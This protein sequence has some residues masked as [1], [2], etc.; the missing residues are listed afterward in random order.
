LCGTVINQHHKEYIV[1]IEKK[2]SIDIPHLMNI[3]VARLKPPVNLNYVRH[4]KFKEIDFINGILHVV[5]KCSFWTDYGDISSSYLNKRHH[6]Y[7]L[8]GVYHC[9][10]KIISHHYFDTKGNDKLKYQ[11]IDTTF[12]KNLYGDETYGMAKEYKNKNGIKISFKSNDEGFPLS[13]AISSANTNDVKIAVLQ[14]HEYID[15]N[16]KTVRN[17]NRYKRYVKKMRA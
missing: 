15:T 16:A 12:I 11:L 10:F 6:L 8:W 3:L 5:N 13:A 17:N 14:N 1:T 2:K 7:C 9:L 4:V